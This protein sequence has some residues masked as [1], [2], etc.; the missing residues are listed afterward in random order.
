MKRSVRGGPDNHRAYVNIKCPYCDWVS[1]DLSEES[2]ARHKGE[3]CRAHLQASSECAARFGP[4]A[5]VRRK[6]RAVP[7]SPE[8]EESSSPKFKVQAFFDDHLTHA[9]A[10][11]ESLWLTRWARE[12]WGVG[13]AA[14]RRAAGG[15][16]V[17]LRLVE[18][19]P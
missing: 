19:A 12:G 13:S 7:A 8:D 5:P 2:E 9:S 18:L 1:A 16:G 10:H 11:T 14:A 17:E 6:R 4:F 15:G 3:V